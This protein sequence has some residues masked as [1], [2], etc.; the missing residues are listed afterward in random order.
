MLQ[1]LSPAQKAWQT[2]RLLAEQRAKVEAAAAIVAA[3]PPRSKLNPLSS[4]MVEINL[5]RADVGCGWRR[6]VVLEVGPGWVKLFSAAM[7]KSV[8][9]RRAE[10]DLKAKATKFDKA[11]VAAIIRRNRAMA[12]RLNEQAKAIVMPD[13]GA[14]AVKAMELMQ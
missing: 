13:G 4:K 5:D 10:F 3:A 1:I 14:D 6:Y 9:I 8:D 7:L 11:A 2:R 12:D